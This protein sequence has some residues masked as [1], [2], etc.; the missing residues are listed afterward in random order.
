MR[1]IGTANR[2]AFIV[3]KFGRLL[4]ISQ[5]NQLILWLIDD[6]ATQCDTRPKQTILCQLCSRFRD[7]TIK[8]ITIV[9]IRCEPS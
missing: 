3:I 7:I 1:L 8:L 2:Y 5:C 4:V 9:K 6:N